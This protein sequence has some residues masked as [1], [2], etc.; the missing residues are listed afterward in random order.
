MC[1]FVGIICPSSVA[2]YFP[3]AFMAIQHRGQDAAGIVTYDERFHIRKVVG[4]AT[5]LFEG[6]YMPGTMGIAH[7]RYPTVGG[8]GVED[9]QPFFLTMPFGLAL[10]HNGNIVNYDDLKDEL[11]ERRRILNSESDAELLLNILSEELDRSVSN[12]FSFDTL[13]D[14]LSRVFM[15]VNGSYSVVVLVAGRGL[16]AFRDPYGIKPSVFGKLPDGGYLFASETVVLDTL[17]CRILGDIAP[18]EVVFVDRGLNLMRRR[19]IEKKQRLCIFEFIYF[20]RPDSVIDRISVYEARLRLGRKLAERVKARSL[21]PDVVIPVPDTARA[22]AVSLASSLRIPY[23][24]GLIKNRYIGRTFIMPSDTTRKETVRMKLNPIRNEI[25]GRR[26]LLVDDSIVRGNTSRAIIE[27]VRSAGAKEVFFSVTSPPLR[28]P[29][30][31]GIDMQTRSEFIARQRTEEEIRRVISA[32]ALVYQEIGDM[33]DALKTLRSDIDFCL[34]C[35]N[36]DYPSRVSEEVLKKIEAKRIR[37]QLT[38]P[39]T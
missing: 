8:G 17:G 37:Y 34:A 38:L 30:V 4:L 20:A 18:G 16:C 3:A 19:L 15:R 5:P 21:Q 25:E 23:R 11:M 7:V 36:G 28:F 6:S 12:S 35:F 22:S 29:C 33:V 1:G 31:Y 10:A 14:A 26:V 2:R 9:A 27:L 24:E 32:D 13:C 39:G